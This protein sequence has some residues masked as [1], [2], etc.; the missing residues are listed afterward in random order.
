MQNKK[1]HF[2]Q[3]T[4]EHLKLLEEGIV[5]FNEGHYW[6]CH[7]EVEDLW[8]DHIGDNARYVYWVVI[9]LAT[10]LYHWEDDNLNGAKG[11]ANKAKEKI[12][13]CE[14]NHVE[15]DVLEKFLKWRELKEI[16]NAIPHN[17]Q[18]ED[19]KRLAKFKFPHPRTWNLD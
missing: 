17:S 13:F 18:L 6:Q 2:G 11:M 10:S 7:E 5:L 1:Y 8:L 19:F 14:N 4:P 12:K 9:Q 16:V 3:F 15:S